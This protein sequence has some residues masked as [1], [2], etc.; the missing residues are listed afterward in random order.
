MASVRLNVSLPEETF[1]ALSKQ[2][3]PRKRSRFI[4]T[5]VKLLLK[6]KQAER[7]SAEYKAAAAEIRTINCELEGT[8]SDGLD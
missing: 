4:N 3:G 1:V 5:A 6:K 2:V 8:V 7:L